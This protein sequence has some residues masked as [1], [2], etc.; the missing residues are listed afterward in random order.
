MLLPFVF[1]GRAHKVLY[2]DGTGLCLLHK[3][4]EQGRFA[5]LWHN[6]APR[7]WCWDASGQIIVPKSLNHIVKLAK[8]QETKIGACLTIAE[9]SKLA[10]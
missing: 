2:C 4:L 3:R 1:V 9:R 10:Q 8:C 5:C 6:P 7:R